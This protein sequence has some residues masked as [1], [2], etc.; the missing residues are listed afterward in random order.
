MA[1][2]FEEGD[3]ITVHCRHCLSLSASLVVRTGTISLSCP[4][5]DRVTR[6]TVRRVSG[7]CSITTEAVEATAETPAE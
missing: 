5:C 4:K 7:G 2:H 6:A 1:S 3:S